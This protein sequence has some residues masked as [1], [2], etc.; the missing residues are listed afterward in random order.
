MSLRNTGV[1]AARPELTAVRVFAPTKRQLVKNADGGMD[2][3]AYGVSP[4]V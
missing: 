1:Y 2:S 3:E 4:S